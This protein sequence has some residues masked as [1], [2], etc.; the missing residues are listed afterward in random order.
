MFCGFCERLVFYF[1][2]LRWF[3]LIGLGFNGWFLVVCSISLLLVL[4]CWFWFSFGSVGL[5]VDG[6]LLL[7]ALS[8]W[9]VGSCGLVVFAVGLIMWVVADW[10]LVWW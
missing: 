4:F 8:I 2:L 6:V 10:C 1:G 9:V 3:A 7:L 5:I